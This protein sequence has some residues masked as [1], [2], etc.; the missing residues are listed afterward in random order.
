M[1]KILVLGASGA[2]GMPLAEMLSHNP[3]VKVTATSRRKMESNTAVCW[4]QGNGK[5]IPFLESLLVEGQFDGVVDFLVYSTEEFKER[6]ELF[7]KQCKHYIFLSSARV[8][9]ATNDVIDESFPRILDVSNDAAYLSTD[10]YELAKARQ[11]DLL[12]NS[13]FRNYTIVRPSLTYNNTRMQFTIFELNEWIYRVFDNNSI[14]FPEEMSSVV[15][16]MTYGQDVASAIVKLLFNPLS[17]GETFNING[18][19]SSTWGQILEIYTNAIQQYHGRKPSICFVK[20][21]ESIAEH[22]NRLGQYKM[23][24]GINRQ[25]SNEKLKRVIGPMEFISIE[26]GLTQ[27]MKVFFQNA[28]QLRYPDFRTAAYLDRLANEYTPLLRFDTAKR[29]LGYALCRFGLYE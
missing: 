7:L 16:T 27:C 18:G 12:N 5:D 22:L 13:G 6:Y 8:Y 26:N 21:V 17:M 1:K 4:V 28:D 11:E 10:P 23:A 3:D 24:R 15:T 25:F 9:A 2:M 19:G 20:N 14:I 29:K